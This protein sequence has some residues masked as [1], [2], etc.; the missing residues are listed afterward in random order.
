MATDEPS[1]YEN[2][3]LP[4]NAS[5]RL[6]KA[7]L[8]K[9]WGAFAT[10]PIEAGSLILQET[11]LFTVKMPPTE[12]TLWAAL[13]ATNPSQDALDQ[14]ACVRFNGERRHI[15][16]CESFCSN[17]FES[18]T[19]GHKG[20]HILLSRFN[21]SCI[22]NA[23]IPPEEASEAGG[24]KLFAIKDIAVG[25]EIMFCYV[26]DWYWQTKAERDAS[27]LMDFC[28]RCAACSGGFFQ[29]LS[30]TRRR[31]M[32]GLRYALSG[33]DPITRKFQDDRHSVFLNLDVKRV[34]EKRALPLTTR[35]IY[36]LLLMLLLEQEG[37]LDQFVVARV[38]S[39]NILSTLQMMQT[40]DNVGTA[41]IALGQKSW[42]LR[43]CY[44]L[45]L[46]G[47]KDA[48]DAGAIVFFQTRKHPSLNISS[49]AS[50]LWS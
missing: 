3:K 13:R 16:F 24:L 5:F 9:G 39:H 44:A 40:S 43:F 6:Q 37:T 12:T 36:H 19:P 28:C 35:F 48:G 29:I 18:V 50:M 21:N 10:K 41:R 15:T 34:V 1:A 32:F 25:E 23:I 31:F 8:D 7:A 45:K 47:K 2:I 14:L 17:C 26:S 22:P 4:E 30:D 27:A 33:A 46:L 20:F 38:W 49:L 42:L 11:A